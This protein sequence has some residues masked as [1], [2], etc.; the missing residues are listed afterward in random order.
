MVFR[1]RFLVLARLCKIALSPAR[2]GPP[3]GRPAAAPALV[4]P[5]VTGA[6]GDLGAITLRP[7]GA[8]TTQSGIWNAMMQAHHPLGRG[9]LCG[10]QLRYLIVS[11]RQGAVGGLAVSAA[12]F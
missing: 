8:S 6:L 1:S 2:R 7:I 3:P 10:A 5:E 4:W 11:Q 9:P 12:A